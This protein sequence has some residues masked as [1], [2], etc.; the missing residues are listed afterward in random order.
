MRGFIGRYRLHAET[1]ILLPLEEYDQPRLTLSDPRQAY[2]FWCEP[3]HRLLILKL[4]RLPLSKPVQ[5]C[6]GLRPELEQRGHTPRKQFAAL[7]RTN[8]PVIR[9]KSEAGLCQDHRQG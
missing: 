9:E 3:K 4:E 1:R 8:R 5:P 2:P 6:F 7:E